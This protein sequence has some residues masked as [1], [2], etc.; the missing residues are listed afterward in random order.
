M[1]RIIE[2]RQ[3]AAPGEEVFELRVFQSRDGD[4]PTCAAASSPPTAADLD[5]MADMSEP[6]DRAYLERKFRASNDTPQQAVS[7]G[8]RPSEAVRASTP[9]VGRRL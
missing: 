8:Q 7:A 5:M 9:S 2:H 3:H 1:T 4:V 6:V